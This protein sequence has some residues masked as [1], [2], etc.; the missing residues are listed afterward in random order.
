[1]A[2]ENILPRDQN[3][4]PAVGFESATTPGLVLPG[5]IHQDT[6]KILVEET[7]GGVVGPGASTDNAVVRWNGTTGEVI[8]NSVVIIGDTGS[9]T[10]VVNITA[11]GTIAA[12]NFLASGFVNAPLYEVNNVPGATGTFTTVDLKTVT[13]VGGIITS[14]V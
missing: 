3:H 9:I 4:V 13:V 5:R 7:D 11:T 2:D 1:M 14:I 8:Q 12:V 10:G 6:G